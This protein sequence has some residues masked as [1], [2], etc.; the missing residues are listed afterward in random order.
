MSKNKKQQRNGFFYYM[1]DMQQELRDQ[2]RN[3]RMSEMPVLAGP[4]WSRLPDA[5]KQAYNQ[6]AKYE[7]R[8][9]GVSGITVQMVSA[10]RPGRM[11]CTGVL[12][13][14]SVFFLF[15]FGCLGFPEFLKF[16]SVLGP[17]T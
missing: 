1:L 4:R 5:Q 2:G 13:S 14:V 6:R 10:P 16:Q 15:F 3:V 17:E 12:L 11:D 9:G 7:K 8:A